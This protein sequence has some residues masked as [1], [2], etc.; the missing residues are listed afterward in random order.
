[1]SAC[2]HVT[3]TSPCDRCAADA[4]ARAA[5]REAIGAIL[6]DYAAGR[7]GLASYAEAFEL[8]ED[9][10]MELRRRGSRAR[11]RRNILRAIDN[12]T[13]YEGEATA[14]A[15][16]YRRSALTD[17]RAIAATMLQQASATEARARRYTSAIRRARRILA[18]L[19]QRAGAP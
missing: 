10:A 7:A 15:G 3:A 2:G 19:D 16:H 9:A 18:A 12:W 11:Y 5:Q 6:A 4:A 8:L 14:R 13:W 17:G 1:M